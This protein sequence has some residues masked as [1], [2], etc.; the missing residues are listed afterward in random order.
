[1]QK[2][3]RSSG[4]YSPVSLRYSSVRIRCQHLCVVHKAVSSES[5]SGRGVKSNSVTSAAILCHF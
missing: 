3:H 1:M 2:Y 5:D 4:G